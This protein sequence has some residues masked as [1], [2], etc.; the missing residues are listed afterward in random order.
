MM[1]SLLPASGNRRES[2]SEV[3]CAEPIVRRV[4]RRLTDDDDD[5]NKSCEAREGAMVTFT[6]RSREALLSCLCQDSEL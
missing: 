4:M 6:P 1:S 3:M 2:E 5:D